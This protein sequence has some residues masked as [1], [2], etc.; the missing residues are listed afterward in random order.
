MERAG[1]R[2]VKEIYSCSPTRI[3]LSVPGTGLL[4]GLT[5]E[6]AGNEAVVM[7]QHGERSRDRQFEKAVPRSVP[8]ME[9][10][11]RPAHSKKISGEKRDGEDLRVFRLG[12]VPL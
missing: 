12:S 9:A 4:S 11:Q 6:H 2:D 5:G 8:Y 3:L 10:L 1:E 7:R